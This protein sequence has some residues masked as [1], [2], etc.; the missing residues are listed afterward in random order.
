MSALSPAYSLASGVSH[1]ALAGA[2]LAARPNPEGSH[3]LSLLMRI[4][5]WLRLLW[6]AGERAG[7]SEI[8]QSEAII[9]AAPPAPNRAQ[10]RRAR[11]R[12]TRGRAK[13]SRQGCELAPLIYRVSGRARYERFLFDMGADCRVKWCFS[14][15]NW[16]WAP[17]LCFCAADIFCVMTP[18]FHTLAAAAETPLLIFGDHASNVIPPRYNNLGLSGADLTRHIAHDIG[19]DSVIR[20]LCRRFG[21]A[22]HICGFS[23]LLILHALSRRAGQSGTAPEDRA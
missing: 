1:S 21:A 3:A 4:G 18:A 7:K 10:Q 20:A 6:D 22:G 5:L 19:T 16:R 14:D 8:I 11:H 9:F 2:V 15:W 13:L 12:N 17:R 23:R